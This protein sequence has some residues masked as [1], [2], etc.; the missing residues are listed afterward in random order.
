MK[1]I[2]SNFKIKRLVVIINAC[3]IITFSLLQLFLGANNAALYTL[4]TDQSLEIKDKVVSII[5]TCIQVILVILSGSAI[6]LECYKKPTKVILVVNTILSLISLMLSVFNTN[7]NYIYICVGFVL[8]ILVSIYAT[9]YE[10]LN[11]S[12]DLD[13]SEENINT[14]DKIL[15]LVSSIVSLVLLFSVF[16][17]PVCFYDDNPYFT[18][19]SALSNDSSL[20]CLISFGIFFLIYI[21]III[22][23]TKILAISNKNIEEFHS[24]V[25]IL[26]YI[27]FAF[28]LVFYFYSIV[29]GYIYKS[30]QEVSVS[31]TTNI[32][33]IPFIIM[34]IMVVIN[35]IITSKYQENPEKE[36]T[37]S[38]FKYRVVTLVFTLLFIGLL[39]ASLFSNIIVI[40]YES[41]TLSSIVTINGFDILKNYHDM[42]SGY[43]AMA[44]LIY[45]ILTVVIALFVINLALFFSKSK[46]YYRFSFA[47]ICVACML[48]VALA[49]YGKY[50]QIAQQIQKETIQDILNSYGLNIT[51]SYTTKVSSQTMYFA[52][53][54]LVLLVLLVAIK[55]FTNRIKEEALNVNISSSD[56]N[57]IPAS[58]PISQNLPTESNSSSIE[59]ENNDELK[60]KGETKEKH[61][62][63]DPCPAFSEIDNNEEKYLEGVKQ[64]ETKLFKNPTLVNIV[65]F[66]VE[67][68]KDSRL[69]LSYTKEDIAQFIAGLGSSRLSIL[70]GMSGTGKTSLPK[71]FSEAVLGT[72]N[73]IE[74]ES[75]WKDKNELIGYYNEFSSKF[76]PKKFTQA[77]Y[78]TKFTPDTI[79][80]IVLDEMNLSRIEYYFSD[81]LSLMENEE[82]KRE[83]KLLNVPLK[84]TKD[85]Q[86]SEYK[87][88]SEGHTIKIPTNVWFIGTANRD[89]STFEI[90]DK[91]YDRAMTMN[92]TKRAKKVKDYKDPISQ[93]YL[94]YSDFKKL[95]DES[96]NAIK[97]DCESNLIVKQ[98]EQILAPFNISFGNRIMNQIESFV[99]VYCS[100]FD[101]KEERINEALEKILLTKVVQKLEVKSIEN[102]EELVHKFEEIGLLKCAEFVNKLN[103]DI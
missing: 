8:S 42:T 83:I 18:L 62:D 101:D 49:L 93:Q 54:G 67:Y 35:S 48:L 95:L 68:A 97:F 76:T 47:S 21:L 102:K 33:Y 91:V 98:V 36:D 88:L 40:E 77:L 7:V 89:E 11:K 25:R 58:A 92:F 79:T 103:E 39:L 27:E 50:Y 53:G 16:L 28:A 90:S 55:P 29:I 38:F 19:I 31:K 60:D 32:A 70:Q 37:H 100:C 57:Q 65:D 30:L 78:K 13:S 24:K 20:V 22:A 59:E 41:S 56:L 99:S 45:I 71:I 3:L 82:D 4:V 94:R 66:V 12:N 46:Y 85:S 9:I 15:G 80:F 6:G 10:I 5:L 43:Q 69:H 87:Q 23:F 17:I 52:L 73:I 63:F 84:I 96:K 74:V 26:L 1:T 81:F 86:I 2:L 44:Y 14:G 61:P 34:G 75:S 51:V 64:K 72:C